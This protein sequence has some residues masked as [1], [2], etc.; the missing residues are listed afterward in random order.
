MKKDI[1]FLDRRRR[2]Y[3]K[4]YFLS[5]AVFNLAW[6]PR[7]ILKSMAALPVTADRI[8]IAAL[9]L[10]VPFQGYSSI[11]LA[12]INRKI[13]KD[14]HLKSALNNELFLIHDMKAWKAGFFSMAGCLTVFSVVSLFLRFDVIPV[15]MTALWTGMGGYNISLYYL[16]RG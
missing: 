10:T 9:A 12:S 3:I 1:E 2:R 4:I 7:L 13:R 15:A 11:A 16:D 5:L 6:I 8:L 14:P